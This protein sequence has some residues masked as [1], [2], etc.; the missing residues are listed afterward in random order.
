[1]SYSLN[2][3]YSAVG[4][5]KQSVQ[6]A[7][8]RQLA[9]DKELESLVILADQIKKAHPGCGVEKMYYT[10][11]PK[12]MGR[13]KF[14][15]I[16]IS[17]GYG[18][19]PV[20]N[21]RKTTIRGVLSYPNLIEG[22][23]ITQPYQ[24]LQSDITYFYLK[25]RFYYLIFIIDVYTR[26]ILGYRVS[27]HMRKEANLKALKMALRATNT[28]MTD[29]IHHSDKGAQ[30]SS[31]P[32]TNELKR[33][34]MHVS[35]GDYATDNAYAERVNGTIKN[36]YLKKWAIKSFG[37]LKRKT[38]TAVNHYNQHRKHRAF[39][40]KFSP[41]E[42]S[43]NLL[44]LNAQDRPKVIIYTEGRKNFKEASSLFEVCPRKEPQAHN[45]PREL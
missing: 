35:M 3:L 30:Y 37:D 27:D 23:Q 15:E 12:F 42:F 32:Y 1:M 40:M 29:T 2:K 25:D 20:R 34:G 22:M 18:V 39:K 38:K 13:D 44:N 14:C 26:V 11:K 36:E 31:L 16:F 33:N 19:K 45:C 5:S 17:L 4:T 24:V 8:K 28:D 43:E 10:L 7:K 9:F 41:I 21:Y 6:Q